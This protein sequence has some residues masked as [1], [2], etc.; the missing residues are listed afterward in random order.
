[1]DI[2]HG[3]K[4]RFRDGGTA[5]LLLLPSIFL[6]L[7]VVVPFIML[8]SMFGSA[9]YG[10]FLFSNSFDSRL[11]RI[12][13]TNSLEQGAAS[14]VLSFSAGLPLGLFLGRYDFRF[15]RLFASLAIL[16]FF[17]PS[18]V[19]VF[20]FLS[21]FGY[22]SPAL[23]VLPW[24]ALLSRG[25]TGI[26]AVNV[27]FNAPLVALT[28]MVAVSGSD[29]Q[30][31]EAA[32]SLG[33]GNLKAF[34]T[35]W[36]RE[37]IVYGIWG[38]LLA[39]IYSFSGFTAPL[40]IGGQKNF[41]LEAWIYF[42][43][44]TLDQIGLATFISVLQVGFLIIPAVVYVYV[45]RSEAHS[46][47]MGRPSMRNR[48]RGPFYFVG[49]VYAC[50][51]AAVEMYL[52]SS[53]VMSSLNF[54]RG[55]LLS[56]FTV[57]FSRLLVNS[58]GITTAAALL[59]SIFYG[60]VTALTA[61]FL[62]LSWIFARRRLRIGLDPM[63]MLQFSP[64][65]IS[66]IILALALSFAFSSIVPVDAVWIL[67]VMAQSVVAIPLVFRIIQAGFSSIPLRF[68]EASALLGG[69]TFFEIEVPIAYSAV[70]TAMLFGF[71]TSLGEFA[72]T[73]F[74]ATPR[75]LSLTVEIYSLQNVRLFHVAD[76]AAS[77]LLLIS[78]IL[79]T[80]IQYT[81]EGLVGIR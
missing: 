23:H 37:G 33:A 13:F 5:F 78:I 21:S 53:V 61:T 75:F 39:F 79:F 52:F 28:T 4:H 30:L 54:G 50:L 43:A 31:E 38:A 64:L 49:A 51:F 14:A 48:E 76:A 34:Y 71:A 72:A 7:I 6:V 11:A 62:A 45:F 70:S 65:V 26:V 16:P 80:A 55:T 36:G 57:L 44:K 47:Y 63:D 10:N 42:V 2:H 25:F 59:N 12:A 58:I 56:N 81:G 69:N 3:L 40:I 77:F 18:I 67:I 8:A 32:R 68:R 24:L 60:T 27:F 74:L 1:V 9:N 41:T 73:N 15:R 22:G 29:P 20:A 17:L 35:T 46:L 19:V 66:A